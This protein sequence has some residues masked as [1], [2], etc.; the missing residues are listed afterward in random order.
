[1]E[2]P[3]ENFSVDAAA[4]SKELAPFQMAVLYLR[5]MRNELE[6]DSNILEKIRDGCITYIRSYFEDILSMCIVSTIV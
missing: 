5:A 1:M 4:I 2:Q 6:Y 3:T